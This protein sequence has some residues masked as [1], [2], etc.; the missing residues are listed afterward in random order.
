MRVSFA[1][2]PATPSAADLDALLAGED[3]LILP[4]VAEYLGVP[5]TRVH[6][7]VGAR[8]ILMYRREG[9]K[10]IPRLLLGDD[11]DLSK[12]VSGAITVL[13]DGGFTDEEILA[14]LFTEDDTLPGRP[15]DALHGHGAREV[16]RRAQ[17]MGF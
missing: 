12:F 5:V 2:T 14:Y 15:V 7:L 16:I 13:Y 11:H 8:K 10:Y 6:D 1:N 9:V 17:A 4:D 3:L